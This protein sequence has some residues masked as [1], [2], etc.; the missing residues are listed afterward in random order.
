MEAVSFFLPFK[1]LF[2][3]AAI[4]SFDQVA[5]KDA[6][7]YSRACI[8]FVWGKYAAKAKCGRPSAKFWQ[9]FW[10][11]QPMAPLSA[12]LAGDLL[13][14]LFVTLKRA[15]CTKQQKE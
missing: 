13:K 6:L 3:E 2:N 15:E 5:N 11:L 12:R 8:R 7:D 1:R 4:L 9:G 10:L 14:P